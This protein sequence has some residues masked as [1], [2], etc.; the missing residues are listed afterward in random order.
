[1]QVKG[2]EGK[3]RERKGRVPSW[4]ITE[5]LFL[6]LKILIPTLKKTVS[7]SRENAYKFMF[8]KQKKEAGLGRG[9]C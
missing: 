5:S 3:G 2:R 4:R 7:I 8:Q 1:M 9:S 6:L